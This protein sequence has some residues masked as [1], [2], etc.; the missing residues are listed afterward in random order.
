MTS[1]VFVHVTARKLGTWVSF[2]RERTPVRGYWDTPSGQLV[3][4][5]PKWQ[6]LTVDQK[7]RLVA[8]DL[9]V[10]KELKAPVRDTYFE[11]Q[12]THGDNGDGGRRLLP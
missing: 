3:F 4:T 5:S 9:T 8:G 10:F 7:D 11:V 12:R 1:R 6:H 2:K